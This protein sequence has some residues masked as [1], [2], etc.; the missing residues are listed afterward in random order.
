MKHALVL[1]SGFGGLSTAALLAKAG[2][3]VTVLEKN[4]Q[5]GGRA[6]QFEAKG[7]TFDMGPSWYLMPEVFEHFFELFDEKIEDHIELKKLAP[8]YRIFW[9][10]EHVDLY[11]DLEKCLPVFEKLEP[12]SSEK[13]KDYLA[14]SEKQYG[15]ALQDF[16]YKNY[17]SVWDFFTFRVMTQGMKLSV[18]Q[19]MQ[20]Y[21]Q[22]FFKTPEMQKIMQ[23]TLVFL[24][25]SPY[26]TPALYNI[27]SHV[28]FNGGVFYPMGGFHAVAKAIWG[29]AEKHGAQLKLNAEVVEIMVDDLGEA[30]GVRLENGETIEADLVVSNIDMAYSETQLLQT[31]HQTYDQKYWD[32]RKMAPSGFVLYLGAKKRF[33]NLKHHNLYFCED[34]EKNFGEIFDEPALPDDPSFYVCA[35]AITE[36][37]FAPDGHENLFVLVPI[38][39]G[40]EITE[41]Q[42]AAYAD[43]VID[44]METEM[45]LEGLKDSLDYKK[46]FTVSDFEDRYHAF[47]GTALGLTHAIS[48]TAIF[49]PNNV[50]KKVKGLYYVGGYTNPGIG[51]PICLI[52]AQ[53]LYKRLLGDKSAEPFTSLPEL[54]L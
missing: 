32:S 31:K 54:K 15:I 11:S 45:G 7:Y 49:R 13:V 23:Y 50:S 37:A 20:N 36:P 48:Q 18:F 44:M 26:K 21:V 27:M 39:A 35:P 22:R 3:K 38:A 29:L 41:E 1:G 46:I 25:S 33:K 12:G 34:W 28:D 6:G 51:V 43:K 5:L 9:G 19:N 40:L 10:G 53:L 2:L 30:K 16:M 4:D 24:G 47:K 42:K 8:S 52:S 14:R 17:D